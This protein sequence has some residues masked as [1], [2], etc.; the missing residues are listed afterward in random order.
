MTGAEVI[1]V[2]RR[3]PTPR[4][5]EAIELLA[6]GLAPKE[7]AFHLGRDQSAILARLRSARARVGVRTDPQLVYRCVKLGVLP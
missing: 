1:R 6:D 2:S 7:I 3:L 5:L 4:Q